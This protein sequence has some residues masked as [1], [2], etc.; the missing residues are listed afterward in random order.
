[1]ISTKGKIWFPQKMNFEFS[2][3]TVGIS[4]NVWTWP[5]L[6]T[7]PSTGLH[8][9]IFWLRPITH[10]KKSNQITTSFEPS[11]RS[12]E[13]EEIWKYKNIKVCQVWKYESMKIKENIHLLSFG[14]LLRKQGR[15]LIKSTLCRLTPI[16]G[17][18]D[19]E[20]I[21]GIVDKGKWK[22]GEVFF[23]G[24]GGGNSFSVA[25]RCSYK[26]KIR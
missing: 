7:P 25:A 19:I 22:I 15:K 18:M 23:K 10:R 16:C 12:G 9:S 20:D 26:R 11:L 8:S 13:G 4:L 1:M 24:K 3:L 2:H 21:E 17:W 14:Q 6:S 5:S